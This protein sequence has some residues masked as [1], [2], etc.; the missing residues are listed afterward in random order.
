MICCECSEAAVSLVTVNDKTDP[1]CQ[2]HKLA[3]VKRMED[4]ARRFGNGGP[5]L[6]KITLMALSNITFKDLPAAHQLERV[7][8]ALG[9][10]EN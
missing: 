3:I 4:A 8:K 7:S 2:Q 9:D 10:D 5:N 6:R 1:V